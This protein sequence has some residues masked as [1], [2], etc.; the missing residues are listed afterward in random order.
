M[1]IGINPTKE[2]FAELWRFRELYY[3][4]T[5]REIKVRYKQTTLGIGWAI[6]QPLALTI[7]FTVV[8]SFLLNFGSGNAPY[9]VFA[10]S[11]LLVWTFFSNAITFGSLSVVT[12]G[13]LVSK[14]YFPRELLPFATITASLFDFVIASLIFLLMFFYFDLKITPN[15]F[16]L[17]LIIPCIFFL[18]SGLS[19]ILSALNVIF[20][21]VRFILPMALQVIFYATPIIYSLN[22]IPD[23]YHKY[24]ALNPLAPLID[25]F[26]DVTVLGQK[27]D[28]LPLFIAF[29]V[30]LIIFIG[31]LI[32][33]RMK[34]KVFADVI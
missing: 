15:L 21:D 11:A 29:L 2:Y 7:I 5:V 31:G 34:E 20:R 22:N 26:R 32:F 27:P 14:I 19:L 6:L 23:K 24:F 4:L 16:Y 12:N 30:S 1:S 10:Y 9:P 13:N 3:A 33:F 18:T 28:L 25:S 8:F 17:F